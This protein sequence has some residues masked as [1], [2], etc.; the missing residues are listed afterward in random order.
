MMKR[1][2][3]Q[4]NSLTLRMRYIHMIIDIDALREDLLEEEYGAFFVG[5]FGGAIVE[6]IQIQNA[7]PEQ[8]VKLARERGFDLKDYE[9]FE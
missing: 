2:K 4:R 8:L 1:I 5:G 3:R 9:V 6:S 7:N